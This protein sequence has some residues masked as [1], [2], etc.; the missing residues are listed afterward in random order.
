[1]RRDVIDPQR[2]PRGFTDGASG[3]AA[4]QR[5]LDEVGQLDHFSETQTDRYRCVAALVTCA[6]ILSGPSATRRLL[7]SLPTELQRR[8]HRDRLDMVRAIE[9]QIDGGSLDA[10]HLANF[11]DVVMLAFGGGP[12]DGTDENGFL[13]MLSAANF[14]TRRAGTLPMRNVLAALA[15][16]EMVGLLRAKQMTLGH[17]VLLGRDADGQAYIFDSARRH[18]TFVREAKSPPAFAEYVDR[19]N[20]AVA[21]NVVFWHAGNARS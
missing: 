5:L 4:S 3:F 21:A 14:S 18:G 15:P 7:A 13:A 1:M 12:K 11:Q 17:M 10:R 20:A 16:G 6:A 8:G 9:R 19:H 2:L